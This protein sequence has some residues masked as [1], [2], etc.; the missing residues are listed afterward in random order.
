MDQFM[1]DLISKG[2][3]AVVTG[4]NVTGSQEIGKT[5]ENVEQIEPMAQ[6]QFIGLAMF[7]KDKLIGWLDEEESKGY[8]YTQGEIKST[9]VVFPCPQGKKDIG[10]ELL[11][12]KEDTQLKKKNGKPQI[13]VN[14]RMEGNVVEAQCDIDLSKTEVINN[15]E[16][17]TEQDIKRS[18]EAALK[19]A[20]KNYQS[21]IFGF[22]SVIYR[23]NPKY[24]N[25]VK[26]DWDKEFQDLQVNVKVK[27]DIQRVFKTK[28]TFQERMEE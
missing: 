25:K 12:T 28:K 18:I 5:K 7:K 17:L 21:D 14:I 19:A 8:N 13:D 20:Q 11:R 26:A 6:L 2:K 10:V 3:E 24:W 22:G 23:D 15:L 1:S 16:K 27:A 4:I 9:T